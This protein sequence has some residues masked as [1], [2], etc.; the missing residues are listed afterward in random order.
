MPIEKIRDNLYIRKGWDGY[1][2]VHPT[3]KDLT[4]P[5]SL[6]NINWK[7]FLVG[8]HWS[9]PLKLLFVLIVL[10]LFV[11]MYLA[12]TKTCREFVENFETEYLKYFD[13]PTSIKNYSRSYPS[14]NFTDLNI[15]SQNETFT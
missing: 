7:N 3:K 9:Y 2:V 15:S 8:G 13:T 5:F 1:R 4:K 14:L 11:Q 10:Y 6:N 12:D